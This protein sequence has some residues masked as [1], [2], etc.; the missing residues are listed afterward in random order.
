MSIPLII[1]MMCGPRKTLLQ[2]GGRGKD[3]GTASR[4]GSRELRE[5]WPVLLRRRWA[6]LA[7]HSAAEDVCAF[8]HH[9]RDGVQRRR[10]RKCDSLDRPDQVRDLSIA[11]AGPDLRAAS[12]LPEARDQSGG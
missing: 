8:S 3:I 4:R 9:A 6:A 11:A 1:E 10:R 2:E 12:G 7:D 5:P